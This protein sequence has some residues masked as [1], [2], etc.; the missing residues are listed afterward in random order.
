MKIINEKGKLFG[1]INIIDLIV[2][3]VLVLIIVGGIKRA[4]AKPEV[5]GETRKALITI[6]VSN[7][8]K[9]IADGFDVGQNLYFQD[10]DS[11]IGEITDIA[12]KPYTKN[13]M[14][15][16]KWYSKEAPGKY[17]ATLT[18]MADV[19]ETSEVIIVGG[20]EVRIGVEYKVK[21]KKVTATGTVLGIEVQ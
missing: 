15:G 5:V 8:K 12:V 1:V 11:L 17:V 14:S 6:E 19:V 2:I 10:K 21:A 20:E 18:V 16:G 13:V 3:I 9:P 4:K 7:V